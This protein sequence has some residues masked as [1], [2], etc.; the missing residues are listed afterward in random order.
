MA[1]LYSTGVLVRQ[2]YGIS[3]SILNRSAQPLHQVAVKLEYGKEYPLGGIGPGKHKRVFVIPRGG[4]S[5]RVD[6]LDDQNVRHSK[7]LAGYVEAGYCG[8]VS[9]EVVPDNGVIAQDHSFV[10]YNWKSWLSFI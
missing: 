5:I 7:L 10:L 4:D 6:F 9:A 2:R 1:L 3:V 8:H